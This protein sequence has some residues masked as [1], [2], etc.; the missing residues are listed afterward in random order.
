MKKSLPLKTGSPYP[1]V[2]LKADTIKITPVKAETIWLNCS[3][4]SAWSAYPP[5]DQPLGRID[6]EMK[7]MAD[8]VVP[9][10]HARTKE[11][12]VFFN[13]MHSEEILVETKSSGVWSQAQKTPTMCSGVARNN[14]FRHVDGALLCMIPQQHHHKYGVWPY[15][16]TAVSANDVS[17][18][19][20]LAST[21]VLAKR[22]TVDSDL[23][24][25]VAELGKTLELLRA[26][27]AEL[28]SK[29]SR[30]YL[31][32]FNGSIGRRVLKD[33]S[34]SYL[35]YRWGIS[36]LVK[37]IQS[38]LDT[39]KR[40][41]GHVRK[42]TR[43]LEQF[44]ASSYDSGFTLFGS[45]R[46]SWSR[47]TTET[48]TVRA[49]S[50]DE[51]NIT[52][53]EQ[54]GFSSKGL[55]KLPWELMSYS[56]VA[57][58]AFNVGD[59]IASS[60]PA[61]GYKQLG[62]CLVTQRQLATAYTITSADSGVDDNWVY[63]GQLNGTIGIIRGSTTRGG[64]SAPGFA[65]RSDFKLDSLTRASDTM[66]MIASRLTDVNRLHVSLNPRPV[67]YRQKKNFELLLNQPGVL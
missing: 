10:F 49:M 4:P 60:M 8:W 32:A 42:T 43:A 26:P 34:S 66:A 3:G 52:F 19:Q 53:L 5:I 18:I 11:G 64:L 37:D 56:H 39:F 62:S 12:Q 48:V 35:L 33:V 36:P 67:S 2:R 54:I 13:T 46:V 51:T 65:V 29:V 25:S 63:T 24:E 7:V 20:T 14:Q 45:A 31:A 50:L 27:M 57:D 17:R 30:L 9:G 55:M 44:T 23:F 16:P 1:R 58:W 47:Q 21:S 61:F 41:A 40:K 6:G 38:V 15:E 22:G 28:K 59:I